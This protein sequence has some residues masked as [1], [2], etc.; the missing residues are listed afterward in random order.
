VALVQTQENPL[1]ATE[2]RSSTKPP[3]VPKSESFVEQELAKVYRRV[4]LRDL[5]AAALGLGI[6]VLAYALTVG[7]ADRLWN[8]PSSIRLAAWCVF[9]LG[10]AIYVGFAVNRLCL[11]RVNPLYLAWQLE[12]T[13]PDAK[14][15]VINWLELRGEPLAPVIR[16]SLSR[17]AARDLKE[18]DPEKAV[19][20]RRI[21]WLG[22]V[23]GV[24]LLI[25]LVWLATAPAQVLSLLQRALL[26]F[27]LV[28][29]AARTELTLVKPEGG[30]VSWPANQPVL[31]RVKAQGYVPA[32]NQADSLKLHFRYNPSEPF[33]TRNLEKDL[34]GTWKTVVLA[35]QVRN[36]FYYKITG[37]D[38]RLPQDREYRVEVRPIPQ[39]ARF[40]VTHHYRPYLYKEDKKQ[41]FD[42]N[43]RLH[44]KEMRGTETTLVVHATRPLEKCQLEL[45][46]SAAK[47]DLLAGDKVPGDRAAWQF[48]F[49]LDRDAD[50]RVLFK[51]TDG[52]DN[53]DRETYRIE[54]IPDK[55]PEVIITQPKRDVTLPANGTLQVDGFAADDHGVKSIELRL[56]VTKGP[57]MPALMAKVFREG[58]NLEFTKGK[59]LRKLD[60]SDYVALDGLRTVS[61]EPFPLAAGMELEYWLE[62]RD[63]CDYPDKN[64]NLGASIH[65]K[66]TITDPE[67]NQQKLAKDRADAEKK[68]KDNQAKQDQMR[69]LQNKVDQGQQPTEQEKKALS[70]QI[71]Q[72]A[73]ALNQEEQQKDSKGQAKGSDENK[74]SAKNQEPQDGS[75]QAGNDKE[76]KPDQKDGAGQDKGA[77]NQGQGNESGTGKDNGGQQSNGSS[78]AKDAG[79]AQNDK[80]AQGSAKA[81]NNDSKKG[82]SGG[83]VK[84][85][86]NDGTAQDKSPPMGDKMDAA[87]QKTNPGDQPSVGEKQQIAGEVKGP[88]TPSKSPPKDAT[89]SIGPEV[90]SKSGEP[91][92]KDL[93]ADLKTPPPSSQDAS[94]AKSGDRQD[95]K[96]EDVAKLKE[97]LGDLNQNAEATSGLEKIG[98]EATDPKVQQAAKQ[99]L[100]DA[101]ATQ[102]QLTAGTKPAGQPGS[103]DV[104]QGTG[105][106]EGQSVTKEGTP[107]GAKA[108]KP[109]S[110]AG[111]QKGSG[112]Q[113]KNTDNA[114]GKA[115]QP[116]SGTPG[117]NNQGTVGIDDPAGADKVNASAGARAGDLLLE[118][119]K[120]DI[121]K[122]RE[123]FSPKVMQRLGWT[124]QQREEF[125]RKLLTDAMLREQQK[126]P[127]GKDKLPL[128][129]AIK[130]LLPST[131]PRQIASDADVNNQA[132]PT[133]NY[134]APP[135][136]LEAQRIFLNPPRPK[137]K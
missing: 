125:L 121:D 100:E 84:T 97:Q 17:H 91:A 31:I 126:V 131:G 128:A 8:L 54:V 46:Y 62:A 21:L 117:T 118:N 136:V 15:S 24:L 69:D 41:L 104:P 77:G 111:T 133:Q 20:F 75:G 65:Y 120:K 23:A 44:L 114:K 60:Y 96:L 58:T 36:G 134:E 12:R 113:G 13:V 130:S 5:A 43:T 25:L 61:G 98:K 63:N 29:I 30:D 14:N 55:A 34:D 48:Q 110:P 88:T 107:G 71:E 3:L 45:K 19:N 52:E 94:N 18:A 85:G 10:V 7:L 74:G 26:P 32:L 64:G 115:K 67:K 51:S 57:T 102:D 89:N 49:V 86:S 42:R 70:D 93:Q 68:Q 78:T 38:A 101:K 108:A 33:E 11:R 9:A 53:T 50:F 47:T 105:K 28:R 127:G 137:K 76:G 123:K 116:G 27:D 35:D 122:L 80:Q 73:K 135:E 83:Q 119:L 37:G 95:A 40:A 66:V 72:V 22:G 112:G 82:D 79:Q 129:P 103:K 90:T 109:D 132:N 6:G 99:A 81:G 92:P 4:R 87:S 16:G 2:T 56:Q 59:Y 106:D 124:D 39:V 1:M